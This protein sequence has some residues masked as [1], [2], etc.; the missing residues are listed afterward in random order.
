MKFI[1]KKI[2]LQNFKQIFKMQ[3]YYCVSRCITVRVAL[4]S[5]SDWLQHVY[6]EHLVTTHI[7]RIRIPVL[8]L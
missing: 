1:V 3:G 5:L 2:V 6:T 4:L 8:S 7:F